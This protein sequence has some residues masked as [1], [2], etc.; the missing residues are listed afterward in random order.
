M[1]KAEKFYS[2]VKKCGDSYYITTY[3]DKRIFKDCIPFSTRKEALENIPA[4]EKD[5]V[6][7]FEKGY[8]DD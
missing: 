7:S 4:I 3:I 5:T 1:P 6:E 2:K 8:F